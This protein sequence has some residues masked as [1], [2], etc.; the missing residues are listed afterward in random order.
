MTLSSL[1][2]VAWALCFSLTDDTSRLEDGVL[3]V[4][5]VE[6]IGALAE[7]VRRIYEMPAPKSRAILLKMH[8]VWTDVV[9]T[10]SALSWCR[11][12]IR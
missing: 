1:T 9:G 12:I 8:E 7:V 2:D 5:N 3:L 4:W 6:C 10:S 11:C